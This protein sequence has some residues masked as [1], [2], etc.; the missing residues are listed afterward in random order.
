MTGRWRQATKRG[1]STATAAGRARDELLAEREVQTPSGHDGERL[2]T[3]VAEL[4]ADYLA[5][6]EAA[7]QLGPNSLHDHRQYLRDY[8]E[9][10]IGSVPA[11]DVDG[12]VISTWQRVLAEREL[13]TIPPSASSA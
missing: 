3:P 5:E 6:R 9:P 1:F 11:G 2:S 8:I 7:Q 10:W 12:E 13:T 4:V